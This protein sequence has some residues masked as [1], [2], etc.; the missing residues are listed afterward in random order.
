MK[1][2]PS[3]ID[4]GY[5]YTDASGNGKS[6]RRKVERWENGRA[7]LQDTNNSSDDF[8]TGQTPTPFVIPQ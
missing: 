6:V 4:A 1:A 2:L 7:Y 3:S 5:S 8:V